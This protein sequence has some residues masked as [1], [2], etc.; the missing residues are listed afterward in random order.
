M[1]LYVTLLDVRYYF[2]TLLDVICHYMYVICQHICVTYHYT[3][4]TYQHAHITHHYVHCTSSI[5]TYYNKDDIEYI[6]SLIQ[7]QYDIDFKL[8][9][10]LYQLLEK[11]SLVVLIYQLILIYL[12]KLTKI[13]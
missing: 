1:S 7:K 8:N 2:I 10:H 5:H 4:D 11:N 6:E 3:H 13:Y 9:Y 12:L